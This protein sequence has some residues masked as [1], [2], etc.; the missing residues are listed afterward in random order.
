MG[1]GLRDPVLPENAPG[2]LLAASPS[3]HSRK[4]IGETATVIIGTAPTDGTAYHET[5]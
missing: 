3:A 5:M 4:A 2:A 1:L